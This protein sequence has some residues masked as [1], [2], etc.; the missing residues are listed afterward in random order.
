MSNN[1]K[2]HNVKNP[3]IRIMNISVIITELLR[4]ILAL[5]FLPIFTLD[6]NI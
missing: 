6:T 4:G 2:V 3:P 5:F 1:E